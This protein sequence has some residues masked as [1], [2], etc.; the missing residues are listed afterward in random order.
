MTLQKP[1]DGAAFSPSRSVGRSVSSARIEFYVPNDS[2]SA[3]IQTF[4]SRQEVLSRS[5]GR[6]AAIT[7]GSTQGGKL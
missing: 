7:R 2:R 5:S 3:T 4:K 1:S 6:S